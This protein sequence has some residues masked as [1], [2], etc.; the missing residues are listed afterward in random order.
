MRVRHGRVIDKCG[1]PTRSDL[2]RLSLSTTPGS[3]HRPSASFRATSCF[4]EDFRHHGLQVPSFGQVVTMRAMA[5]PNVVNV[6]QSSTQTNSN[7]FLADVEV[8]WCFD[9]ATDHQICDPLFCMT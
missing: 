7:R 1:I 9:L 6:P 3:M 4:A 2:F 5:S 8:T